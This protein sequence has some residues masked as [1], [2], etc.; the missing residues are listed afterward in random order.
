MKTNKFQLAKL[1]ISA[2]LFLTVQLSSA[3]EVS[4]STFKGKVKDN[5]TSEK[6]IFGNVSIVG[7]S[8]GTVTN[9]DGEFT[10]K[11]LES[12]NA[13]ELEF[14]HIGYIS[15][16]VTI[17]D[18]KSEDNKI[19]LTPSSINLSEV[20]IRPEEA[21]TLMRKVVQN[22]PSNYSKAAV[23][24]SGFYRETIKQGRDYLSISE[25]VVDIYKASYSSEVK[26]R[27]KVFK[28]R[29]SSNVK[30]ADTLAVKLQGG[31]YTSLL[32]DIAKNPYLLLD[33]EIL[34]YYDFTIENIKKVNDKLNYVVA[35]KPNAILIDYPTY[36]GKYYI[37]I[38]SLAIT[39]VEFS[40]N[41]ED[42][43][44]AGAM[45]VKKRPIGLKIT[46]L[47]TNYL[48][49]YK[50]VDG[51]YYFNYS[52]GEFKFKC[53][54]KKKLFNSNYA[55]MSE[56]AITS[57]SSENVVKFKHKES[58]KTTA[59]FEEEVSAFMDKDFW[60][61]HNFIEPDQS[62]ESAIKKYGKKKKQ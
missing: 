1:I 16:K 51:K 42:K 23:M 47:S 32:V 12:L 55:V 4:Y 9:S 22:I 60:G 40:L 2:I 19:S 21:S 38:K 53:N 34:K 18:L 37:E 27:V 29:K 49:T 43:E 57:W 36:I 33:Q 31:P 13:V 50:E 61:K 10:I 20:T 52:R 30:K 7:T 15:K 58:L 62:I 45:F 17:S 46:P 3:Q 48:V 24:S 39:S 54:W 25:A 44:N 41:L 28:G 6:I 35:F 59:V 56:M 11:V 8:I 14:S 26:D 5:K